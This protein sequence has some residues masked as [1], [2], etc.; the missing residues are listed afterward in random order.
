M[1]SHCNK[2]R[3]LKDCLRPRGGITLLG[4]S[5][6]P[7][8]A[9][10]LPQQSNDEKCMTATTKPASLSDAGQGT[11]R[12]SGGLRGRGWIRKQ[13]IDD[14]RKLREQIAELERAL[15]ATADVAKPRRPSEIGF[16]I[17]AHRS[18]LQRLEHCISAL[19]RGFLLGPPGTPGLLPAPALSLDASNVETDLHQTM[20]DYAALRTR[21]RHASSPAQ[22]SH[23]RA[24]LF[25]LTFPPICLA[26]ETP[27]NW[28][29][30]NSIP[31]PQDDPPGPAIR[32]HLG[33]EFVRAMGIIV[34][35]VMPSFSL[36][37]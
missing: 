31:C 29:I 22:A 1:T 34:H 35:Q 30:L 20:L 2:Q 24:R 33:C 23:Q 16:Q 25:T 15:I 13:R 12:T 8:L 9:C 18:R 27:A 14:A 6:E 4:W 21:R 36:P 17:Q 11:A 3:S 32:P 10:G 28:R 26:P 5:D 7:R 19:E 37:E